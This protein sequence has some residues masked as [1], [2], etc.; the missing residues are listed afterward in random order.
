MALELTQPLTEMI[1]RNNSWQVKVVG[2]CSWP[3]HIVLKTA[4]L[5]VLETCESVQ[6]C[7]GIAL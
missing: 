7:N 5:N 3:Y 4:N 2:A 1:T 6:A